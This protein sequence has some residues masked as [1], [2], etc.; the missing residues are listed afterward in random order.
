MSLLFLGDDIVVVVVDVVVVLVIVTVEVFFV[1]LLSLGPWLVSF[2]RV[3]NISRLSALVL[4]FFALFFAQE[5]FMLLLF[6][7]LF[8]AFV[9][10]LLVGCFFSLLFSLTEVYF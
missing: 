4:L 5:L 10:F 1:A 3:N 6:V 7:L 8:S 9:L 2:L